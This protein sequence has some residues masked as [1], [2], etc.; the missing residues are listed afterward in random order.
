MIIEILKPYKKWDAGAKVDVTSELGAQ[1]CL[2]GIAKLASDQ[3]RFDYQPK[4]EAQPEEP[5]NITIN[6]Y[7]VVDDEGDVDDT[8][9]K[10]KGK[11]TEKTNL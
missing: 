11:K 1:L 5:Q 8:K 2:L 4:E 9:P 6:N 7:Y 3:T 10:G